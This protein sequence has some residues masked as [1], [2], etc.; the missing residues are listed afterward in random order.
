[1]RSVSILF[2]DWTTKKWWEKNV[3]LS[4]SSAYAKKSRSF[5]CFEHA[6]LLIRSKEVFFYLPIIACTLTLNCVRTTSEFFRLLKCEREREIKREWNGGREINVRILFERNKRRLLLRN[7]WSRIIFYM[8]STLINRNT[9]LLW[10]YIVSRL[11]ISTIKNTEQIKP[12]QHHYSFSCEMNNNC[13]NNNINESHF[14]KRRKR[15]KK[16]KS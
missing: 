6:V 9:R 13:D 4:I 7:D 12:I 3:M 10:F 16:K 1:M 8:I 11:Y 2:K 14:K 15:G 5:W